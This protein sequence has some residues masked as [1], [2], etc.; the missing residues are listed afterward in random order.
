MCGDQYGAAIRHGRAAMVYYQAPET[1]SEGPVRPPSSALP[2][3]PARSMSN[4]LM[5]TGIPYTAWKTRGTERPCDLSQQK[6]QRPCRVSHLL[7]R[8]L[9]YECEGPM[10]DSIDE[11]VRTEGGVRRLL[12]GEL[13]KAK[14]LPSQWVEASKKLSA[15]AIDQSTCLH[16]WTAA[17]DLVRSWWNEDRGP[18]PDS[19]GLMHPLLHRRDSD[20]NSDSEGSE[21]PEPM[22]ECGKLTWEVPDLSEGGPFAR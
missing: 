20:S 22:E 16:L 19:E 10:P 13:A 6:I 18:G 4:M 11:W 2:A 7:Y 5:P 17:M 9:I 1:T 8:Q 21:D 3:L 12:A 15:K 14:G